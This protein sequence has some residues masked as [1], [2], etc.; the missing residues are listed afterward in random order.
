MVVVVMAVVVMAVLVMVAITQK[1]SD[2]G[3]EHRIR[4]IY[5][6]KSVDG[7]LLLTTTSCIAPDCLKSCFNF[8]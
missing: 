4:T 5:A 7:D 8:P 1:L 2:S 3:K 6:S